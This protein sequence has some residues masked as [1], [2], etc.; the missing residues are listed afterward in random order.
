MTASLQ[1]IGD[2]P[3][4]ARFAGAGAMR[5]E[6]EAVL[7]ATPEDATA[8][9]YRHAILADNAARKVSQTARNWAWLRLKLR[10]A[11]DTPSAP[12]FRAFRLAMRDPSPA[13]R[14]IVCALMVARTDRLFRETTVHILSPIL[15]RA[16]TRIDPDA[17]LQE[18]VDRMHRAELGWSEESQRHVASH[19]M[20]SWR[21]LGLSAGARERCS[22]RP[23]MTHAAVR[24]AVEVARAEGLTD[25]QVLGSV[26]FELLGMGRRAA[27]ELLREAARTGLLGFRAQAEVVEITLP[28]AV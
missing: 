22:V 20:S 23:Q 14:G 19:I 13:G 10:Y 25:Q 16:G 15:S 4:T 3:I 24:F 2:Q 17:V 7:S 5:R 28:E 26:W 11:L 6:L 9:D 1:A 21:E 18:V 8:T 12:E 27:E